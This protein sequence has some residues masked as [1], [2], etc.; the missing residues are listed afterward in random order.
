MYDLPIE[1]QVV[2]E[3]DSPKSTV[4]VIVIEKNM[5]PWEIYQDC[6]LFFESGLF[7]DLL[8]PAPY[9]R[10][11]FM[12]L[13]ATVLVNRLSACPYATLVNLQ[14]ESGIDLQ[15]RTKCLG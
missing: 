13:Y 3:T 5:R 8:G 12:L 6:Q 2:P 4:P 9:G 7:N 1:E 15:M 14:Q 11:V 10:S